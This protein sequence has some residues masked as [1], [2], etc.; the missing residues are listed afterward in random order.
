MS[1]VSEPYTTLTVLFENIYPI[2]N[3]VGDLICVTTFNSVAL[4]F[5]LLE[6]ECKKK[7]T[8]YYL[9]LLA[10]ILG[11]TH[12]DPMFNQL[13]MLKVF[14]LSNFLSKFFFTNFLLAFLK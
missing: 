2:E 10:G 7:D 9:K 3:T 4:K 13:C 6:A 14:F 1:Q 8:T 11:P 5:D 12:R